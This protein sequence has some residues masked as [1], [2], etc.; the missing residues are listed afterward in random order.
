MTD[1]ESL[2]SLFSNT[3]FAPSTSIGS[4]L[5]SPPLLCQIAGSSAFNL[6]L[7]SS[8]KD[9]FGVFLFNTNASLSSSSLVSVPFSVD[10]HL[11]E[12]HQLYEL[13]FYLQLLMK[14]NPKVIEP[15]FTDKLCYRSCKYKKEREEKMEEDRDESLHPSAILLHSLLNFRSQ[16]LLTSFSS[17]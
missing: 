12:D 1:S 6:N 8:D 2:L 7:P 4:V 11:P 13:E 9:Y 15:I 17:S 10:G 3:F 5:R 14:G 16:P